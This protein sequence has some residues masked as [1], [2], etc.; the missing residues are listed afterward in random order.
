MLRKITFTLFIISFL[1]SF[2]QN[3][4]KVWIFFT[5]KKETTFNP[6]SYFDTKAIERRIKHGIN[7]YDSS[8]FPV[9]ENYIQQ[10]IDLGFEEKVTSRWM[11]AVIGY[12][13]INSID[14][15]KNLPFVKEIIRYNSTNILS[16]I[17][18]ETTN[19]YELT[20]ADARLIFQ[21]CNRMNANYFWDNGFTGKGVRIAIFDAGFPNVDKSPVF[22]H[23]RKENRI[24]KT[25]DFVKNKEFVYSYATHGTNV[26][27]CIAGMYESKKLGLATDAEFLL[28][29][30]EIGWREPFSEEENW[31][32]AAEWADK[33][34]AH[35]INSSLGYTDH[36]YFVS[37]MDGKKSFVARA[38]NMAASKGILVVNAAGNEGN[39]K[40]KYIGTPADADSVLS[41][42]AIDPKT[43]RHAS[44][45]SYGPT[46]DKRL[47]PNVSAYGYVI[48][49]SKNGFSKTQGTSFASPL[50]AGFAACALQSNPSLKNMELFQE[51]ERSSTLYPYFDYVH[52]YGIPQA[53]YFIKKGKS[54]TEATFNVFDEELY[55]KV[56][57][58]PEFMKLS[59]DKPYVREYFYYHIEN[60]SGYLDKYSVLTTDNEE[61][62]QLYKNDFKKG[63]TAR[64]HYKGYT[65]SIQINQ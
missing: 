3:K 19:N 30:T 32:A 51:I 55:I 48:A 1:N 34:G 2:A 33:N 35:I 16:S 23:I 36:R 22:E 26:L 17:D 4:E 14:K 62:I 56:Y 60:P 61:I 63:S 37:D 27:S 29:R 28:A 57:L 54:E 45:S 5:D 6:Y 39:G 42:G 64:F 46:A 59:P 41:V 21:Q 65:Y 8:D 38:A 58:K 43:D 31:L 11:N 53:D 50:V 10:L 18:V 9:N 52:G 44:F 49:E 12:A 47:K 25:Y 13:D 15:I 40:W 20:E 24:I 7:L